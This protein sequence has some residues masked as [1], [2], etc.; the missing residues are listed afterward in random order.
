MPDTDS[1]L[2]AVTDKNLE[3]VKTTLPAV[4]NQSYHVALKAAMS[5]GQSN[6]TDYMINNAPTGQKGPDFDYDLCCAAQNGDLELVKSLLDK[7]AKDVFTAST[8]ARMGN[9]LDINKF[10]ESKFN[11]FPDEVYP[12][13][14]IKCYDEILMENPLSHQF[15]YEQ[16]HR[17]KKML[18]DLVDSGLDTTKGMTVELIRQSLGVEKTE[19]IVENIKQLSIEINKNP[20]NAS[21]FI[22][23]ANEKL[24]FFSF[25]HKYGFDFYDPQGALHDFNTAL[26][27]NPNDSESYY[28]RGV[29]W[30]S[31]KF[32][33][34][35]LNDFT[36]A[37]ELD[38]KI[39]KAYFSRGLIKER[40]KD[41]KG[42]LKDLKIALDLGDERAKKEIERLEKGN[43]P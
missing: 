38:P 23:R 32:S 1:L 13:L 7:G 27:L 10:L 14:R 2:K 17:A 8:L 20:K 30:R 42:A 18:S 36:T 21:L 3:A 6:I 35:A 40:L 33:T 39:V 26:S 16:R 22:K 11:N 12:Q 4:D 28:S 15:F 43:T 34:R 5:Q 29:I 9:Y 19:Q 25:S 31:M 24:V 41:K 37:I